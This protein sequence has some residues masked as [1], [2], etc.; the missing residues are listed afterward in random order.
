MD[1]KAIAMKAIGMIAIA[2]ILWYLYDVFKDTGEKNSRQ[3]KIVRQYLDNVASKEEI[4]KQFKIMLAV[5]S[6]IDDDAVCAK[7]KSS[8]AEYDRCFERA[9]QQRST[10]LPFLGTSVEHDDNKR[11]ARLFK[12]QLKVYKKAFEIGNESDEPVHLSTV[13]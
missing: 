1:M 9:L 5:E 13:P 10:R 11:R 6:E 12:E 8:A 7:Q 4:Q 3:E 2:V